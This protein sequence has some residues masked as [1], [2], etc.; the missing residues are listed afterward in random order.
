MSIFVVQ[1]WLDIEEMGCSVLGVARADRV[2]PVRQAL[3]RAAL[4][5]WGQR[6]QYFDFPVYSPEDAIR[7]GL[8]SGDRPILLSEVS[9]NAGAGATGDSTYILEALLRLGPTPEHR[10][11]Y[12]P[13]R[14]ALQLSL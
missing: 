3:T 9:D 7:Q 10:R 2:G 13:V 5:F 8:A 12:A 11:S 4:E 14:E 6:A 1:C